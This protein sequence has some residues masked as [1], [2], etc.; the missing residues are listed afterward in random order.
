MSTHM[1]LTCLDHDPPLQSQEVEQ[2][3]NLTK[4]RQYIANREAMCTMVEMGIPFSSQGG[5]YWANNAAYFLYD[6][7]KC[8]IGIQ[9]EY[10]DR[11]LTE[12]GADESPIES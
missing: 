4:I 3:K 2:H 7:Q 8:K 12:I 9:S 6:H 1:F 11:Y 10:G 5:V